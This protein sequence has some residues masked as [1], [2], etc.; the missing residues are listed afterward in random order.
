MRKISIL[1][2]G[3]TLVV[4]FGLMVAIWV[5]HQLWRQP[6]EVSDTMT[7]TIES[8]ATTSAIAADLQSAGL[9]KSAWLFTTLVRLSGSGGEL[10]A[11]EYAIPRG[12]GMIALLL[13]LRY[14]Q[15][16]SQVTITIPEGYTIE[17]IGA[18]V[19]SKLSITMVEWQGATGLDSPL[20]HDLDVT[21][22]KPDGVDLEGYLFP[23][24][25]TFASGTTAEEVVREMIETLKRRLMENDINAYLSDSDPYNWHEIMTMASIVEREVRDPE[26]MKLVA[27]I[28]WKRLAIGMALQADSTVNYVTGKKTPGVS[29]DDLQIDSPYNTYKY[30]GLPPGPISNPGIAAISAAVQPTANQYYYFLTTDDGT[31]MYA[32]T[33]EEHLANK[34]RYR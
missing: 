10:Q 34:A 1:V 18:L 29:L 33:Y 19:Q 8:G 31:V 17:Q 5:G 14:G 9:I 32:T 15:N 22:D 6:P 4:F 2:S 12:E 27:D 28:F 3:L 21:R 26:D 24:T 23:D 13:A 16:Q 30:P 20:A 25:Y 11:G 7:F